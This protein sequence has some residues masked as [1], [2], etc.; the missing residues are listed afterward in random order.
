MTLTKVKRRR[1]A[2]PELEKRHGHHHIHTHHYMRTYWPYLPMIAILVFGFGANGWLGNIHRDVL[3]YATDMSVSSLLSD[4]NAQRQ[5]NSESGLTLNS[6]LTTA[7][8]A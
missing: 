4:T 2:D 6:Q 5:D 8:Q 3:G 1:R 7:A